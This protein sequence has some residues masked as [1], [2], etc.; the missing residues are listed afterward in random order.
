MPVLPVV[1]VLVGYC[2]AVLP[3]WCWFPACAWAVL[4]VAVGF[5]GYGAEV[6]KG[7]CEIL[8]A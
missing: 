2:V 8:H 6:G 4:L 3:C 5:R 1:V 7:M